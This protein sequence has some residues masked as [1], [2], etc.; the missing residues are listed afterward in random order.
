MAII[1]GHKKVIVW[2]DVRSGYGKVFKNL[3]HWNKWWAWEPIYDIIVLH[4][5]SFGWRMSCR[6]SDSMLHPH[7]MLVACCTAI[8]TISYRAQSTGSKVKTVTKFFTILWSVQMELNVMQTRMHLLRR[9]R[10]SPDEQFH[11][12]PITETTELKNWRQ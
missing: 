2:N 6:Q 9:R 12:Q 1:D 4:V 11:R 10:R 7:M 8:C 3:S 5:A